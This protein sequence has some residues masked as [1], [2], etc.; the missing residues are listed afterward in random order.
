M[1]ELSWGSKLC[2]FLQA[3]VIPNIIIAR[4]SV[5]SV[6]LS[7]SFTHYSP[8]YQTRVQTGLK[9]HITARYYD[10]CSVAVL[11]PHLS[12]RQIKSDR[13]KHAGPLYQT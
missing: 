1:V 8:L 3:A 2:C 6:Q 13:T 9:E 5:Y 10:I 11:L 7:L 4:V 12:Y